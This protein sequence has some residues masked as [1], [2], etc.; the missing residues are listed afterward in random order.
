MF[1][2][3]LS[4]IL[5]TNDFFLLISPKPSDV[6]AECR[7]A[8]SRSAKV[9]SNTAAVIDYISG[10]GA[11]LDDSCSNLQQCS[12]ED[13]SILFKYQNW[14]TGENEVVTLEGKCIFTED[15]R[16]N[17]GNTLPTDQFLGE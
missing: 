1:I 3:I 2:I 17:M 16:P 4:V 9:N 8:V 12:Q 6:S 11:V 5:L 7:C 10:R 13:C 15:L 14:N